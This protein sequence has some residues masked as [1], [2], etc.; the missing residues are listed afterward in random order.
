MAKCAF[1]RGSSTTTGEQ[2]AP[3]RCKKALFMKYQRMMETCEIAKASECPLRLFIPADD[4]KDGERT[5][6]L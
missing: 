6:S 1:S 3:E 4:E 5:D 2:H